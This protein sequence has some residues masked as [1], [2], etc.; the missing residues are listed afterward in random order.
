MKKK[1]RKTIYKKQ[2]RYMAS[3]LKEARVNAKL[4]QNQAAKLL[5]M[6]QSNLSKIEAGLLRLDVFQVENFAKTYKKPVKYFIP[7][8]KL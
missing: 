4:T 6:T 3:K 5:G 7:S 8:S 2:H 1:A